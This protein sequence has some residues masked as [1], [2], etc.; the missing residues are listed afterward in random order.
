MPPPRLA[1]E[2]RTKTLA[3]GECSMPIVGFAERRGVREIVRCR[4]LT[5]VREEVPPGR[6]LRAVCSARRIVIVYQENSLIGQLRVLSPPGSKKCLA[7]LDCNESTTSPA[8]HCAEIGRRC[9]ARLLPGGCNAMHPAHPGNARYAF[10]DEPKKTCQIRS[11]GAWPRGIA[12]CQC[13]F[14]ARGTR[15]HG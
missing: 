13:E 3:A 12:S 5:K 2:K 9:I 8:R 4:T 6:T 15:C 14:S 11:H 10:L 7:G 1:P